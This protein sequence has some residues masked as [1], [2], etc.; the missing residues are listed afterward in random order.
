MNTEG[1]NY[2]SNQDIGNPIINVSIPSKS[3]SKEIFKQV[4]TQQRNEAVRMSPTFDQDQRHDAE[5]L[6]NDNEQAILGMSDTAQ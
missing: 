5:M 1:F 2:V 6:E 4:Q 3:G